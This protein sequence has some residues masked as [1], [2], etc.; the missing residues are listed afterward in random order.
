MRINYVLYDPNADSGNGQK[1]AE[2]LQ[3]PGEETILINISRIHSYPVFFRG[4]EPDARVTLCGDDHTLNRFVNQT[5][6]VTIQNQIY[7]FAVGDRND[8]VRDLDHSCREQADFEISRYLKE[9]P[10][11]TVNGKIHRF[12]NGIGYGAGWNYR[13]LKERVRLVRSGARSAVV[14]VDGTVNTYKNVRLALVMN[15]KYYGGMTPAPK[16]K[17]TQDIPKLSLVLLHSLGACRAFLAFPSVLK[18]TNQKQA[19]ILEGREI[20]VEFDRN[21]PIQMDGETLEEADAFTVKA[22]VSFQFRNEQYH[23][24]AYE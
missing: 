21:V 24:T 18:G 17:R 14:T 8:F 20:R 19:T 7:F 13:T 10:E 9:L 4:M 23:K 22:P 6:Q 2:A 16:Q 3:K 5:E 11:T 1:D 15:G 12:L